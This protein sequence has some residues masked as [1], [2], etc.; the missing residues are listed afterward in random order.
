MHAAHR[1]HVDELIDSV[2]ADL[3]ALTRF[4]LA[5]SDMGRADY[6]AAIEA[7]VQQRS[8]MCNDMARVL[9][10]LRATQRESL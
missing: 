1:R 4:E 2:R 3:E 8:E 7:G 10:M 6:L 9:A 5:G